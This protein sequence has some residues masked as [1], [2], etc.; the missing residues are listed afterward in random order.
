VLVVHRASVLVYQPPLTS[1]IR[2][3]CQRPSTRRHGGTEM[4]GDLC[5]APRLRA[6]VFKGPLAVRYQL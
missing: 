4:R 1:S 6:S 3:V 2:P 5:D